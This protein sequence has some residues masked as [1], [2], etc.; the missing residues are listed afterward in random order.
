MKQINV[1]LLGFGFSGRFFHAPIFTSVEGFNL[2]K[3]FT[4][5]AEK[6]ELA[7]LLYPDAIVVDDVESIIDDPNIDLI[8]V[9]LPN[10]SH[11]EMAERALIAGKHVVVEKPFTNTLEEA[12]AL[13][14]TSIEEGK[15]LSVFQNRRYDGDFLTLKNIIE[16][17]TLGEIK[18]FESHFDRFRPE[19]N[20]KVWRESIL[21]G[22]GILFDLGAHL[23]DQAIQL[24]GMPNEVYADVR[25]QRANVLVDDNFEIILYYTDLK[26]TL[27]SGMLVKEPLP[28]FILL[29]DK[30]SY[31]KYGLDPQEAELKQ[32]FRPDEWDD[33]GLED[34]KNYG[35][36]N[37][38]ENGL[39]IRGVVETLAGNYTTYYQNIYNA[40][41]NGAP[42]EVTSEQARDVIRIIEIA[43][44]SN[45]EKR[46]IALSE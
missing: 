5:S 7:N 46:R 25:T 44:E 27:K 30:G 1:G 38:L 29:G 4:R 15:L 43:K 24:F 18:E 40:I 21:P 12:T 3:I 8:I 2:S 23:I 37:Y 35:N 11:Y 9:A 36:I 26:V 14:N 17:N 20:S 22:S 41:V 34:P 10:T 13:I 45:V 16:N 39:N 32:N 19:T 6:K 42:L 33:W 28:R 31:V